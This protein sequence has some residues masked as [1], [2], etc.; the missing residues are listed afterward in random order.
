MRMT[1]PR[2]GSLEWELMVMGSSR[3]H[4]RGDDDRHILY[5]HDKRLFYEMG[6]VIKR[7]IVTLSS[8][9]P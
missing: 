4:E 7:V 6:N 1:L 2:V 9:H 5:H 8:R 3:F